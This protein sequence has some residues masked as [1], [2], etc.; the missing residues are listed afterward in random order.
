MPE[1]EKQARTPNSAERPIRTKS[2]VGEMISR[3][4]RDAG[5]AISIRA[6]ARQVKRNPS[7]VSRWLRSHPE[8]RAGF[9]AELPRK[10][11]PPKPLSSRPTGYSSKRIQALGLFFLGLNREKIEALTGVKSETVGSY[12]LGLT[13]TVDN[14]RLWNDE[15][16]TKLDS[17]LGMRFDMA[18]YVTEIRIKWQVPPFQEAAFLKGIKQREKCPLSFAV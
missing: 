2:Q 17:T 9:A 11:T 15:E 13:R 12:L 10:G 7:S 4:I 18:E 3:I 14:H 6:I 1:K 16:V 8:A 5:G